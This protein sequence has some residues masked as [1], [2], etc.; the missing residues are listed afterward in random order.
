MLAMA[1]A[2][3]N[4]FR[5]LLLD[6]L[7]LGLAPLVVDELYDV[8]DALKG[9]GASIVVVEQF[10]DKA[11]EL[12]DTVYVLRKGQVVHHGPARGLRD[13]P[14]ALRDLYFGTGG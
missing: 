5:L 12:A 1:S 3:G 6:E 4:D 14:D 11:L 8:V 2:I 7:S 13:R 10:A 9:Q